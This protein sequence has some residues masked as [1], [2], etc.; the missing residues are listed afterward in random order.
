MILDVSDASFQ[1]DVL[2]RSKTVP[3]I[4]DLWAPWCEPCKTIGP[5]LEKLV[6]AANGKVVLAKVN[7]DQN[8][9]IA[10]AFK[11]QSIPAVYAMKDGGVQDGFVGAYPE[12][13]IE[14]FVRGL[15]PAE[16]LVSVESLV[17]LGDEAS[18]RQA[19]VVEPT[20][21]TAIIALATLLISR[22]DIPAALELLAGA[23]LSP[24]I[25]LLI[26][27]AKLAFNPTDNFDDQLSSLLGR[28]KTDDD[29]RATYLQILETM[30][31]NDPRTAG[32]RKKFTAQLF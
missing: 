12:H 20:N 4:V 27:E 30:G 23:P 9:S 25:Q 18:L 7:V 17:G 5:I 28:V 29:T 31:P 6:K 26:D 10:A 2:D 13:V 21:E 15:L 3:V 16:E 8:P 14:E 24:L 19:L 22:V 11:A 32:H 1:A